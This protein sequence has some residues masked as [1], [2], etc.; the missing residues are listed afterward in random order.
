M[1]YEVEAALMD[2]YPCLTNIAGGH[3]SWERGCRHVDQI[4]A[5]YKADPLVV[6][7]PLIL[8]FIGRGLDERS[9][10]YEAVRAAWRMARREAERRNL[11]LAY[12]DLGLV[13][14]AYRP[15]RWLP[16]TR[17]NFPLLPEDRPNRIGFEG[18]PAED[19]WSDYVGKRVPTRKPGA[20][21]PFRYLDPNGK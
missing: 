5:I 15:E 6:K 11:V 1:A 2:A 16:A 13:V 14:G 18:K 12:D 7:E 20:Q 17:A 21:G 3:G 4:V 9:D 10:P 19:V 8:I